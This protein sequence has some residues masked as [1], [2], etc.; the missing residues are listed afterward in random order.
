MLVLVLTPGALTFRARTSIDTP[1]ALRELGDIAAAKGVSAK[2]LLAEYEPQPAASGRC[3]L[4]GVTRTRP[5]RNRHGGLLFED[6]K[7]FWF[8]VF[9]TLTS[10]TSGY[11]SVTATNNALATAYPDNTSICAATLLPTAPRNSG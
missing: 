1:Q 6:P 10:G 7:R 8:L 9:G 5:P 11:N 4:A 3:G 2:S